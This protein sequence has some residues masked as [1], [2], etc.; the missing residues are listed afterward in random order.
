MNWR[1][2]YL[3]GAMWPFILSRLRYAALPRMNEPAQ[4]ERISA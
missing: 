2:G 3:R 4:D 1:C